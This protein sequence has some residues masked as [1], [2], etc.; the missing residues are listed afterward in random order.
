MYQAGYAEVLDDDTATARSQERR[1]FDHAIE[2]FLVLHARLEVLQS[3]IQLDEARFQAIESL[4]MAHLHGLQ[5]SNER[6]HCLPEERLD[7]ALN[8]RADVLIDIGHQFLVHGI[9]STTER[10]ASP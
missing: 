2:L 1:A 10:R 6:G 4:D 9:K 7:L 5:M 3:G 8:R